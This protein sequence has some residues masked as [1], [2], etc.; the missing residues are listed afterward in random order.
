MSPRNF[1]ELLTPQHLV[2]TV[3]DG[4]E[5]LVTPINEDFVVTDDEQY[6][7]NNIETQFQT[8]QTGR[9]SVRMVTQSPL[10]GYKC[11]NCYFYMCPCLNCAPH[12]DE[13]NYTTMTYAEFRRGREDLY[14]PNYDDFVFDEDV[15]AGWITPSG[16]DDSTTRE[17]QA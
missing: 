5:D 12:Q 15:L 6:D 10:T 8:F 14:S 17:K 3:P 7:N 1:V 9:P 11:E 13:L 4:N 2:M 16:S